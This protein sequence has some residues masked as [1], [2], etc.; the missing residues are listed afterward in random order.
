MKGKLDR[1]LD[2]LACVVDGIRRNGVS[3]TVREIAESLDTVVSAVQHHIDRLVAEGLLERDRT[4]SRS[5]RVAGPPCEYCG[6]TG[7]SRL[8]RSEPEPVEAAA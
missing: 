2:V 4:H 5:L 8:V 6:G 1:R 3:P 7:K